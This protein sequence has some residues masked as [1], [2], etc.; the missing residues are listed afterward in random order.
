MG[1]KCFSCKEAVQN[2][3]NVSC[4]ACFQNTNIVI[5]NLLMFINSYRSRSAGFQLKT[6][7]LK[8]YPANEIKEARQTLV[9]SVKEIIPDHPHLFIKRVDSPNRPAHDVMV[10]DLIDIFKALDSADQ[11]ERI[12]KFLAD[13]A[14][15]IPGCPEAAGNMM[16]LYDD[17]AVQRRELDKLQE[18]MTRV[19][20]DVASNT[21]ELAKVKSANAEQQP[22]KTPVKRRKSQDVND[23]PVPTDSNTITKPSQAEPVVAPRSSYAV[24]ASR[25][26]QG[27]AGPSA[28][29]KS[30]QFTNV[31]PNNGK[32]P[33][34]GLAKT[35][36]NKKTQ[37]NKGTGGAAEPSG[38]LVAGPTQFKVQ[39]TNVN[40]ELE[41]GDIES[42][43]KDKNDSISAIDVADTSSDG[44]S[45]KRFLLT[46]AYEH[47]N[48]VMSK[49]FWPKNIYF[50][51]WYAPRPQ[52]ERKDTS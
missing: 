33:N 16:S 9:D 51:R 24:A 20:Q 23:I 3:D 18:I 15:K 40:P 11:A 32:R 5:N 52:N 26:P 34:K 37:R 14:L 25:A 45:T 39:I 38:K 19:I 30:E 41:C 50:K 1:K 13:D 12:P 43:I 8:S 42:Y 6:A 21:S 17:L 47:L 27:D 49:D 22:K 10:D 31:G 46:F 29:S 35:I 44:W 7:V 2:S 4:V 48:D 28:D 36:D